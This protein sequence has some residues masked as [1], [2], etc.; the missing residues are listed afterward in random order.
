MYPIQLVV[1]SRKTV[2][3]NERSTRGLVKAEYSRTVFQLQ[4]Y[5]VWRKQRTDVERQPYIKFT[6]EISEGTSIV[7]IFCRKQAISADTVFTMCPE[8]TL[9]IQLCYRGINFLVFPLHNDNDMR[10]W[11]HHKMLNSNAQIVLTL[12]HRRC[13]QQVLAASNDT[14]WCRRSHGQR[15]WQKFGCFLLQRKWTFSI[16]YSVL[17]ATQLGGSV[18]GCGDWALQWQELHLERRSN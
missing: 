18:G 1:D 14:L 3:L 13:D 4:L 10:V 16:A 12:A 6:V 9:D 2:R 17:I 8:L 7:F 5:C 11:F 15:N